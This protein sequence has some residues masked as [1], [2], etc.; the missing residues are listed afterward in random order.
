LLVFTSPFKWLEKKTTKLPVMMRSRP[1]FLILIFTMV[2]CTQQ[3]KTLPSPE[4]GP[5]TLVIHGG[6]GTIR[7]DQMTPEKEVAYRQT[8]TYALDSGF[9]VLKNGGTA[10]QAVVAS[11]VILENSPLF[12]AG[13]GAVFNHEGQNEMDAAIMVGD[14]LD[15]GAVAGISTIKNP[16]TAAVAV[17][18]YST[19]VM[20]SG[21]GADDFASANGCEVMS[22]AYFFDSTRYRQLLK[23]QQKTGIT[24]GTPD[25]HPDKFGTVGAVA[26]DR[27][28]NLAA[29]TSTG[30]MTNK[31]YGRI[32]DS[33]SLVREP[34]RTM[35]HVP[36]Q[37]PV[38]ASISFELSPPIRSLRCISTLC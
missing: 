27:Y 18:N 28:G 11:I 8:L 17:M 10:E 2:A 15:A 24:A 1:N 35:N 5:V 3:E 14:N 29:G 21:K 26:L 16:I 20:M 37:P 31:Q 9:S 33:L 25:S 7:R 30:G 13:R 22:P 4:T 38:M 6:A 19:H 36:F 12:N 34:M 23:A 32:G